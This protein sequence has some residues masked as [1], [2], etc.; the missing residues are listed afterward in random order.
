MVA[1]QGHVITWGSRHTDPQPQPQLTCFKLSLL[2]LLAKLCSK[3]PI[4]SSMFILLLFTVL[5]ICKTVNNSG[6]SIHPRFLRRAAHHPERLSCVNNIGFAPV[7]F[8][9]DS[10]IRSNIIKIGCYVAN[11][12][13]WSM[14]FC[15][16][17]PV[18]WAPFYQQG[19]TEIGHGYT[20][21]CSSFVMDEWLQP[22][23]LCAITYPFP[24]L[25]V[26]L[27]NLCQ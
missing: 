12:T 17:Y 14:I 6:M 18:I 2:L 13:S 15:V 7:T 19:L 24:H 26:A 22:N 4:A 27:A 21:T 9:P 10:Y 8:C 1:E 3:L 20:H 23:I 16:T 11:C 5:H 25:G